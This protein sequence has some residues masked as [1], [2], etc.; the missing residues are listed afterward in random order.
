MYKQ[1]IFERKVLRAESIFKDEQVFYPNYF[2]E[3]IKSRDKL[4]S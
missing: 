4:F 2:P 3:E 1:N